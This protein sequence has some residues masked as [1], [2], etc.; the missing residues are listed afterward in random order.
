M[1]AYRSS[2]V[3]SIRWKRIVLM[4]LW[5]FNVAL[6]LYS[7]FI[8]SSYRSQ[9]NCCWHIIYVSLGRRVFQK[10]EGM[11]Y[12]GR[13]RKCSWSRYIF[14]SCRMHSS[15]TT[16]LTFTW[17]FATTLVSYRMAPVFVTGWVNSLNFFFKRVSR[18]FPMH[19]SH[20]GRACALSVQTVMAVNPWWCRNETSLQ[21]LCNI[22]A[23]AVSGNRID[24]VFRIVHNYRCKTFGYVGSPNWLTGEAFTGWTV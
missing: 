14:F 7:L 2:R 13:F 18:F 9:C 4:I 19:V 20:P 21:N 8:F 24:P 1:D 16:D 17:K 10:S 6:F 15:R 12:G 22:L 11:R 23:G 3:T 5:P